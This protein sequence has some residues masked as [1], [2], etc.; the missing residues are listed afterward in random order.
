MMYVMITSKIIMAREQGA[1]MLPAEQMSV[2]ISCIWLLTSC[3]LQQ[4]LSDNT[5]YTTTMTPTE[6]SVRYSPHFCCWMPGALQDVRQ[7]IPKR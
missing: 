4:K 3:N 5:D 1:R 6:E 7:K 2:L